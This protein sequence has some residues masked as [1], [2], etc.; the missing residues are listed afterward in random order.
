LQEKQRLAGKPKSKEVGLGR[1]T[2]AKAGMG[3]TGRQRKTTEGRQNRQG[4]VG[5]QAEGGRLAERCRQAGRQAG[6]QA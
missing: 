4:E 1:H 3:R 6:R 2:E 5:I